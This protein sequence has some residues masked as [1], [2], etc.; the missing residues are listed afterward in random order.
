MLNRYIPGLEEVDPLHSYTKNVILAIGDK[1]VVRQSVYDLLHIL[2]VGAITQIRR[3]QS[4]RPNQGSFLRKRK[5]KDTEDSGP[6][7]ARNKRED[8]QEGPK[9]Q[10][11]GMETKV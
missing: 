6:E 7:W 3:T 1:A 2:I 5:R 9:K 10:D 8:E 4:A 11:K